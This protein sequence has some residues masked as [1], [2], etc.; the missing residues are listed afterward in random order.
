[1]ENKDKE[2]VLNRQEFVDDLIKIV[3]ILSESGSSCC[4]GID[5]KWGTG[6]TFVLEMFENNISQIQC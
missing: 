2:D 6:K 5:G 3:E 4:F 1:M